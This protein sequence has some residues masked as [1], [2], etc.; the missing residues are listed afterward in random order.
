MLKKSIFTKDIGLKFENL[1]K[2]D[3]FLDLE[4]IKKV[5]EKSN[6]P[7]L[8]IKNKQLKGI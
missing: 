6:D 4:D 7:V 8:R 2:K 5:L 1:I 3:V